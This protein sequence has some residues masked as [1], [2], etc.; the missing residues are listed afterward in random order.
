MIS[1]DWLIV[2][3]CFHLYFFKY[4]LGSKQPYTQTIQY[5]ECFSDTVIQS[6]F[7]FIRHKEIPLAEQS[8]PSEL[9]RA[10]TGSMSKY[11]HDAVT[12]EYNTS[13]L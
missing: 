4:R 9:G 6:L 1:K 11:S 12:S 10:Q 13:N 8:G 7:K 5:S 3:S 2:I